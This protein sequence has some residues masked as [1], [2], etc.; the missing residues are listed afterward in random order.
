MDLYNVVRAKTNLNKVSILGM[1]LGS[2]WANTWPYLNP[3][4]NFVTNINGINLTL[5]NFVDYGNCHT[6][7]YGGNSHGDA[8]PAAQYNQLIQ[9][10]VGGAAPSVNIGGAP[11]AWVP[12]SPAYG[13]KPMCATETGYLVGGTS[14]LNISQLAFAK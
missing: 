2:V 10:Y 4:P 9:Q 6:Y 13:D 14:T 5:Q 1:A 3:L 11:D 7:P 12:F 8:W